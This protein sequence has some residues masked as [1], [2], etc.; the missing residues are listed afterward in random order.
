[1]AIKDSGQFSLPGLATLLL[2]ALCAAGCGSNPISTTAEIK[3][4]LE[5]KTENMN[6]NDTHPVLI[7]LVDP[8]AT[9]ETRSLFL[10]LQS[11]RGKAILFGHQHATTHGRS[12]GTPDG[13]SS[14]IKHV[15]GSHPAV[16]GWDTLSL[17]GWERPGTR[18]NSTAENVAQ[19][20]DYIEK[21]QAAGGIVTI[22][23]HPYNF[24]TGESFYDATGGVVTAI[25]PGG[26]KND[27]LNLYLDQV[28]DLAHSIKDDKGNPIPLIFRPFHEMNGTWF[29]WGSEQATT[30]EYIRLYRY[31]VKYLRDEKGVHNLLYAYSPNGYFRGDAEAY[32]TWYPGDEYVD[33]LGYDH[34]DDT[35][36]TPAW[37]RHTVED[38]GM[39]ANLADEKGKISA[40]TEFGLRGNLGDAEG[41]EL[42]PTWF[43]D[44]HKALMDDPDA[45]RSAY[46]QSW[47]NF[48]ASQYYVPFPGHPLAADLERLAADPTSFFAVDLINVYTQTDIKTVP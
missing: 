19:L 3:T 8:N 39:I 23:T 27:A 31:T 28:A 41:F 42:N 9:P 17:D 21:A 4:D 40:F 37:L 43:T 48:D 29:W 32:L 33:I 7:D 30:D 34:Y 14:D 20:A 25:L 47:A 5:N 16:F 45:R 15:V 1:M 24:L 11:I 10:Y 35:S 13:T 26:E 46:M 36:D 44:M 22:S 6:A 12:I 2:L 18:A 38:L